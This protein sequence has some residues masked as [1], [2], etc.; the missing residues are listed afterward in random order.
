MSEHHP[1]TTVVA[2]SG[3]SGPGPTIGGDAPADPGR[4]PEPPQGTHG[5]AGG[6]DEHHR[7]DGGLGGGHQAPPGWPVY[8]PVVP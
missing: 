3:R 4:S 6:R 5:A 7:A 1:A 8:R 2:A